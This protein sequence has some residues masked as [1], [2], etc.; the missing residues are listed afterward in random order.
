MHWIADRRREKVSQHRSQAIVALYDR[1]HF[2]AKQEPISYKKTVA[3]LA[4]PLL[5]TKQ[6]V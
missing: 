2:A 6:V 4:M 5:L 3:S 1:S